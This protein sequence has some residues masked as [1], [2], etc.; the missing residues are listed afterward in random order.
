[1]EPHIA[2]INQLKAK[3]ELYE[4]FLRRNTNSITMAAQC[5]AVLE[6]GAKL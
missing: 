2:E 3:V 5:R 1:M 6:E 4:A